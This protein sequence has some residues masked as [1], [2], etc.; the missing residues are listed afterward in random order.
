[1]ASPLG[2][3]LGVAVTAGVVLGLPGILLAP[4]LLLVFS[5]A[6]GDVARDISRIW[7]PI[8][9]LLL[10]GLL[11]AGRGAMIAPPSPSNIA[12][13]SVGGWGK[14]VTLPQPDRRG[15][16]VVIAVDRVLDLEGKSHPAT[17]RVLAILPQ[18]ERVN[19]GDRVWLGWE[20]RSLDSVSPGFARLVRAR[21]ASA[22]VYAY[23]VEVEQTG[24]SPRRLLVDMRRAVSNRL[25]RL[26][27]GDAG[28]LAAGIVSGDD[29]ALS[30][31]ALTAFQRTG[32]SH[33]TAVSGQNIGM[34]IGLWMLLV[35]PARRRRAWVV[36]AG[37]IASIWL[38][39]MFTGFNPPS[40]RAALFGT[41]VLLAARTGRRPD[42]ATILAIATAIMV[43]VSPGYIRDVSFWLS[44]A[45]S[46]AL[47]TGMQVGF[48]RVHRAVLANLVT[49]VGAQL[50]TLPLSVSFFGV[51]SPGSI[52]ANALIL[53]LVAIAFPLVFTLA[54]MAF[55]APPVAA[56]VA[57]VP[58]AILR[59]IVVIVERTS[60][61]FPAHELDARGGSVALALLVP[62]LLGIGMLSIDAHR[63]SA[64]LH[65]RLRQD[66]VPVFLA[67]TGGFVG[68]GAVLLVS[69]VR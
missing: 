42:L 34:L 31:D 24:R 7:E 69:M 37:V 16:R 30:D 48:G 12:G 35:R 66:P 40:V 54:I 36:Q 33:I 67:L 63:W 17:G 65:M 61:V 10:A 13:E 26:I 68:A 11:G 3:L 25:L 45:A 28:A 53:P 20:Y 32:T 19:V 64:R 55:V 4:V 9:I 59:T 41:L 52:V 49:V 6:V 5:F 21:N 2:L 60:E 27:P 38:Y 39:A 46:A 18:G 29:T 14:V 58:G 47:V 50:A 62:C 56:S 8:V 22:V 43:L 1:M 57:M 44:V 51:W 23:T 15:E